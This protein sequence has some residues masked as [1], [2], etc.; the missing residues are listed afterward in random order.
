MTGYS[1]NDKRVFGFVSERLL[2]AWLTTNNIHYEEL[3]LVYMEHQNWLHKGFSFL[4]RK[5]FPRDHG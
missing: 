4:R 5:F 3:D 2:D 1:D